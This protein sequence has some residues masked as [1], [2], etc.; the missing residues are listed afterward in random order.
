MRPATTRAFKALGE[1]LRALREGRGERQ[2]EAADRAGLSAKTLQDFER[3]VT[4]PTLAS[5]IA[6][7]QAYEVSIGE[8]FRDL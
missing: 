5:I 3:G 4:N 2:E 8:L 6:V 1:R 7:A